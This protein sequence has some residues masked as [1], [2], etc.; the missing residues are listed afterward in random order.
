MFSG[1]IP[2]GARLSVSLLSPEDVA[3]SARDCLKSL[4]AGMAENPGCE[5]SAVIV[6]SC[7]ARYFV[8]AGGDNSERAMIRAMPPPGCRLQVFTGLV[9]YARLFQKPAR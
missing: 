7:V 6:V 3:A 2:V 5:Y 9:K 8:L 1:D 4:R